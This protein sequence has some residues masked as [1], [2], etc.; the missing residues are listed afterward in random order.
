M[1]TQPNPTQPTSSTAPEALHQAFSWLPL[2]LRADPHAQFIAMTTDVCLG[3]QTCVDLAYFSTMDRGSDTTPMLD[4]A[5]TDRLLRLVSMSS[6]M[7]A[8]D[9][10]SR[11][12]QRK[13]R[14]D[15]IRSVTDTT[16]PQP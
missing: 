10:E 12:D 8:N 3:I 1:P 2:H 14:S 6:Q 9:A 7:L 4:V 16:D 5:D 15:K 13:H 11:I